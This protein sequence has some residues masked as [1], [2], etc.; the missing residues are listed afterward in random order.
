[1]LYYAEET[2]VHVTNKPYTTPPLPRRLKVHEGTVISTT[3]QK[4]RTTYTLRNVKD[5]A[6][7]VLVEYQ[8]RI[9]PEAKLSVECHG[10]KQA[11]E[12][13]A[14]VRYASSWQ[15]RRR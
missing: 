9:S 2:G 4:S 12:L 5:E 3:V 10:V 6:F 1:M 14:G 15:R 7:D 13:K 8:K 11:E